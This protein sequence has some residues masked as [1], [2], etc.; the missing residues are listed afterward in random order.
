MDEQASDHFVRFNALV[1]RGWLGVLKPVELKLWMAYEKHANSDGSDARPGPATLAKYL[2]RCDPEYLRVARARLVALGLFAREDTRGGRAVA[3]V[4]VLVPP[5]NAKSVVAKLCKVDPPE[6]A[7]GGETW[8]GSA[9]GELPPAPA[10]ALPPEKARALS[11][12]EQTHEQIHEQVPL[13]PAG[14]GAGEGVKKPRARKPRVLT[15]EQQKLRIDFSDWWMSAAWPRFHDGATYGFEG[16][17]DGPAVLRLLR[18][19]KVKWDLER[20]KEIALYYLKL[21]DAYL[22]HLGKPLPTL[23][24]RVNYYAAKVDQ[25]KQQ[26]SNHVIGIAGNSS[27][28]DGAGHAAGGAGDDYAIPT[29]RRNLGRNAAATEPGAGGA[30]AAAG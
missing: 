13:S 15:D 10:R 30:A 11:K 29:G 20:A 1:E 17:R 24:Q 27:D 22:V 28:A 5:K 18:H 16:E 9:V 25:F 6:T 7:G 3:R 4:R 14:A 21:A 23:A 12:D 26:G 8:G 19:P 2:G